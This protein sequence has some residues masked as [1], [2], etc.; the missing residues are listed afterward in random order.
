MR[1]P[2][3][4][5]VSPAVDLG[6]FV[7]P[8]LLCV[9]V[10]LGLPAGLELSPG[11]WLLVVVGIDVAHVYATIWRTVLVPG[12]L[13]RVPG[14]LIGLPL[15]CFVGLTAL[16]YI[17]P[18]WFWTVLAY[19]A[20]HHFI[21]Q[22]WGIAALYRLREGLP[23]RTLD[24]RVEKWAHYA[25]TG[26]PV[27]WWHAHLP[28]QFTWFTD[29]DFIPGLPAWAAWMALLPAAGIV[30]WHV[31]LR[32]DS[33]R[34]SPGRDLWLLTTA[35]VWGV[36]ILATDSDAAFSLTNVVHHGVPYVVLV[37]WTGKRT[38]ALGQPA[39]L[40]GRVYA[41]SW[42][43]VFIAP[44]VILAVSEEWLWDRLLWHDHPGL[45]GTSAVDL[46]LS[47]VQTAL[48]L[49]LLSTPQV[50]H[51]LLDGHIWRMDSSNPG[52]RQAWASPSPPVERDAPDAP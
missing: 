51:Y 43:P 47:D 14:R 12:E 38:A 4:W 7:G 31:V 52:L 50:S 13:R 45:F 3:P 27:L 44:L 24:A 21:R 40:G 41:L 19:L 46:S 39:A 17:A 36:G 16:A 6:F 42:L 35:L 20:V 33:G 25:V 32:V 48:V 28:R 26:W 49:G 37:W 11:T 10:A 34:W 8:A 1:C 29:T 18:G 23:G 5:L 15:L 30:V 9:L 22:Q 2:V